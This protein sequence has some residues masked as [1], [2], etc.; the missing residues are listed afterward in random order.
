MS[1]RALWT[2]DGSTV[3]SCP[4]TRTVMGWVEGRRCSW[5]IDGGR[6]DTLILSSGT[7]HPMSPCLCKDCRGVSTP[8]APLVALPGTGSFSTGTDDATIPIRP[9]FFAWPDR[10]VG[11]T[12]RPPTRAARRSTSGSARPWSRGR[13]PVFHAHWLRRV[14]S[15]RLLANHLVH[16][17]TRDVHLGARCTRGRSRSAPRISRAPSDRGSRGASR[18]GSI[19][20][21]LPLP[22][23][24]GRPARWKTGAMNPPA[25]P[26]S[27]ATRA[28]GSYRDYAS[29]AYSLLSAGTPS[30]TAISAHA[31]AST[32]R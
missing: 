1:G 16:R 6:G 11:R 25:R 2:T 9:G 8:S 21:R 32:R 19:G 28:R 30:P 29:G 3:P 20:A 18:P 31:F 4:R 7:C 27:S 15:Q 23:G 10:P 5:R 13:G 26:E 14:H 24:R 12:A 22:D 17:G